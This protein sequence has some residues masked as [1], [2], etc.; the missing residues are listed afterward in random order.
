VKGQCHLWHRRPYQQILEAARP[1][2]RLLAV[3]QPRIRP[4]PAESP[5]AGVRL[6]HTD[7]AAFAQVSRELLLLLLLLRL[8]LH[9]GERP[10]TFDA[11]AFWRAQSP[12]AGVRLLPPAVASVQAFRARLLLPL[13]RGL[14]LALT[15]GAL[16]ADFD[17]GAVSPRTLSPRA[18]VWLL[19]PALA[20]L[21]ACRPRLLLVLSGV[22]LVWASRGLPSCPDAGEAS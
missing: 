16:V 9:L 7:F 1:G 8:A 21:Q 4:R 11:D 2:V 15:L 13:F 22:R 20:S 12:R 6:L 5:R 10:P 18:G 19:L 3:S 17:A 14:R